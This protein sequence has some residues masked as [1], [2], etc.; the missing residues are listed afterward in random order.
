MTIHKFKN[1]VDYRKFCRI[2]EK[3]TPYFRTISKPYQ[4]PILVHVFED[5]DEYKQL[6]RASEDKNSLQN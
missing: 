4:L 3:H 5:E 2:A 6:R 1:Q